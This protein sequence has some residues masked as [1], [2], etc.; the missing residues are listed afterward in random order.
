MKLLYASVAANIMT[1]L[2]SLLTL[3]SLFMEREEASSLMIAT[4]LLYVVAVT[5]SLIRD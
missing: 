2:L 3:I 5:L 4:L 1:V